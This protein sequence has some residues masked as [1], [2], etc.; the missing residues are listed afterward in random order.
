MRMH[1]AGQ[2]V[3]ASEPVFG[4]QADLIG[5][6]VHNG[7][8]ALAVMNNAEPPASEVAAFE[9]DL[10]GRKVKAMLFNAQASEP[11]V[12]RLVDIAKANGVPVVGVTETEPPGTTYQAW[13]LGQLDALDKAL[14]GLSH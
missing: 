13:M 4:Y 10:K 2:P 1:Y 11:S 8:F 7:K 3:S 12:R 14:A 6:D 5:L 9:N